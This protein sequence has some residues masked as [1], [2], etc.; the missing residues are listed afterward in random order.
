MK[1]VRWICNK[2]CRSPASSHKILL[3]ISF[4]IRRQYHELLSR[5]GPVV[6]YFTYNCNPEMVNIYCVAP[7]LPF[8]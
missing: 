8:F 2:S 3:S 7:P 6:S 5:V 4:G 1:C